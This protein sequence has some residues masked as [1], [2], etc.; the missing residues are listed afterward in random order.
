MTE[1]LNQEIATELSVGKI[2]SGEVTKVSEKV[3]TVSVEG[4]EGIIPIS[5]LS[6]LHVEK[7]EDVVKEGDVLTLKVTKYE[8]GDLVLSKKAVDAEAAWK[9]LA[10]KFESGEIFDVLVRDSVNG[11]LVVDLGVRG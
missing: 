6:S 2:V 4:V 7:A 8:D 9:E 10:T 3:V 1:N 5:E 11:G